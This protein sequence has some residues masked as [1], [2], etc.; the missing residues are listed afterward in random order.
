MKFVIDK[1]I[2]F[3]EGL[4]EP[5]ATVLYKESS[6]ITHND[7]LGA[8]ALLIRTRTKCNAALLEGTSVKMI[9]SATVGMDHIDLA[10]CE[11]YG[12][13]VR[14]AAGCSSNA[15]MNYVFSALYGCAARLSIDLRGKTIGIIGVGKVGK[16]VED[17][18]RV[19]GFK[20][21]LCDPQRQ[22]A[23]GGS[24]F[25]DLDYLLENSD[26]V[27]L[28]IPSSDSNRKLCNAEFFEK[29][30]PGAFFINSSRGEIVDEQALLEASAKLGPIIIDTWSNEPNINTELL[31]KAAIGTPHI[32]GYSL[33]AKF[34]A[35][36]MVV[37]NV[38][39]FFQIKEL[40]DFIPAEN[41]EGRDSVHVDVT[42][43]NQGQIASVFQYNYP[44]FTDDFMFRIA[45]QDFEK[46]R[47]NYKYRR[48]VQID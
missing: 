15:V 29:M 5:Y 31:E 36:T 8:D 39:R 37:R 23:E 21:L 2:P 40:Y 28:H 1:S 43:M 4:F 9:A 17:T 41:L 7:I 30:K 16:R 46:I 33:Q 12:I 32:S 11:R 13:N 25:C 6:E 48:E 27:T 44:I 26:I 20:V 14:G 35:A 19:L 42:G 34:A 47:W 45:P 3:V 24:Q 22:V 18:A 38:A 10:Y